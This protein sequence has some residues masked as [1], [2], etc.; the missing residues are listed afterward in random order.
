MISQLG[1]P[2][3]Y[4]CLLDPATKTWSTSNNPYLSLHWCIGSADAKKQA[5]TA[6][7]PGL[8]H[9]SVPSCQRVRR[10]N[11]C[12]ARLPSWAVGPCLTYWVGESPKWARSSDD[13]QPTN[14]GPIQEPNIQN[15]WYLTRRTTNVS[16][17]NHLNPVWPW[18]NELGF[19]GLAQLISKVLII[20]PMFQEMLGDLEIL[21]TKCPQDSWFTILI[22][23]WEMTSS[24]R[25][26]VR[27]GLIL[28]GSSAFSIGF[29]SKNTWSEDIKCVTCY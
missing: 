5:G 25:V 6:G 18:S 12:P 15:R 22:W 23:T 2:A 4:Q 10:R 21:C 24:K 27:K 17:K 11:I 7:Q 19:W 9:M 29:R 14:K 28:F 20:K 16:R 26:V 3:P 1:Q 13:G 8:G